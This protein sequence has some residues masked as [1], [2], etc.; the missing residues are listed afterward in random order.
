MVDVMS[1]DNGTVGL[2]ALI[3]GLASLIGF[4]GSFPLCQSYS[5]EE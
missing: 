4:I 1:E 2:V 5:K 3:T